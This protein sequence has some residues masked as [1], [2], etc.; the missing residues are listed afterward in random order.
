[1]KFTVTHNVPAPQERVY[2][3]LIDPAVIQKCIE[4][5]ESM[6]P[7]GEDSWDV[8]LRVGVAMIKG[9][10]TGKVRLADKHP[11]HSFA[12][13]MEG[14]GAPGWVKGA[15]HMHLDATGGETSVRCECDAQ[16]GGVIA[17]VGSRLIE[18]AARRM[19]ADFFQKLSNQV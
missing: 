17:A 16:V 14:K 13:H 9:R 8:S 10:Y 12:L 1:M 5:C 2:A 3:A 11:P 6:T 7:A 15:A 19:L 4:G 18:A